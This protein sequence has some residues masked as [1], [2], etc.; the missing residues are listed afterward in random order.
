MILLS[1]F[2]TR[3]KKVNNG[4]NKK[5]D[6]ITIVQSAAFQHFLSSSKGLAIKISSTASYRRQAP[7]KNIIFTYLFL[8]LT[9]TIP[10]PRADWYIAPEARAIGYAFKQ[11]I[12]NMTKIFL[13]TAF[14]GSRLYWKFSI[15]CLDNLFERNFSW[16]S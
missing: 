4:T 16:R 7:L 9:S 11:I 6:E 13:Q 12:I 14:A 5:N 3:S 15:I 1:F 2:L 10:F 8:L